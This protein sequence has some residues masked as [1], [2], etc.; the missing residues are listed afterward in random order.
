MLDLRIEGD[1][2]VIEGL[3]KLAHKGIPDATQRA[4]A[5]AAMGVF[6]EAFEYLSGPGAERGSK[7][8]GKPMHK[9]EL[10]LAG[11]YPVP[12]RTGNLRIHLDWLAPSTTKSDREGHSFTALPH[13]A[14]VYDSAEYADVIHDGKGSSAKFGRRPYLVNAF[15]KFNQGDRIIRIFEEEIARELPK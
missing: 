5:R 15:Q 13:E 3:D 7:K 6:G 1:Q 8:V 2:V 4:L 11:G 9:G 10:T 14:I 12:V